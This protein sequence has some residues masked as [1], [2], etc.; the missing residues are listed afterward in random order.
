[1]G[2]VQVLTAAR[3][4]E[5]TDVA[6]V[7]G[8]ITDG[9]LILTTQ[10]GD[11]INAGSVGSEV[12]TSGLRAQSNADIQ[13]TGGDAE[14][15]VETVTVNDDGTATTG[16]VNRLVYKFLPVGG[17]ARNTTYFNEYGELRAAPAK[18][19]TTAI[20]AYVKYDPTNPSA[21]RSATVPVVE[22]VDDPVNRNN[23]RGWLG[24]GSQVVK[25]VKMA[26]V[27]V[28]GPTDAIPAGTLSGTLILRSSSPIPMNLN[29]DFESNASNWTASGGTLTRDTSQHNT[30]VASGKLV[31]TGSVAT[32]MTSEKEAIT[33][34]NTYKTDGY[35]R[36]SIATT[37]NMNVAW[38]NASNTLV[39]TS[40]ASMSVPATT[41]SHI[42]NSFVAPATATQASLVLSL[43]GTPASGVTLWAD[44]V[45][46][47]VS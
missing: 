17:V 38:Y 5:L 34:G 11:E 10:H 7:G 44:D 22:M 24:D 36:A 13:I 32:S 12:D 37:V 29:P 14:G 21:A 30:G 33:A 46:L 35:L 47:Y 16:W 31:A 6:V 4:I 26:D 43:S 23:L 27:L 40:T 45:C 2:T 41:W 19:T 9:D 28:L 8:V 39:S 18:E 3:T 15:V 20:R 1:M 42:A 25:G